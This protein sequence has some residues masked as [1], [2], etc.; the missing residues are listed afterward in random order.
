MKIPSVYIVGGAG[1]GKSTFMDELTAGMHFSPLYDLWSLKNAKA[2]VTLRGHDIDHNGLYLGCMRDAFPG[3]DGLDRAS[4]PTGE[5]WLVNMADRGTLPAYIVS[6]GATLSTRRFISAMQTHT[7]LLLVHLFTSQ[8]ELQSRFSERGSNQEPSFVLSTQ[9]RSLNLV[10]D[11]RKIGVQ[12]LEF[13]S[14]SNSN[15]DLAQDI[16]RTHLNLKG[17]YRARS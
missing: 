10:N 15:W 6:E 2:V 11:M 13:D 14:A 1:S 4:S 8:E 3:T 16:C 9:T 5:D 17:S 12:V 7:N